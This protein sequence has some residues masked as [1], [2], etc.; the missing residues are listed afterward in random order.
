MTKTKIV[1][2]GGSGRSG[3]TF[4][5]LL[6]SQNPDCFDIGQIRDLPDGIRTDATCSCGKK[7]RVCE[8]WGAVAARMVE[9]FGIHAL[10]DFKVGL[11]D[12]SK[13][14]DQIQDW[15]NR[16]ELS[17]LAFR[18]ARFIEVAAGLYGICRMISGCNALIDSSKTPSLSLALALSSLN[19]VYVL[20]LVRDPRAVCASWSKL[21]KDPEKL[22]GHQRAWNR[23]AVRM[24]QMENFLGKA[25]KRI[26]YEDFA[27]APLPLVAEIQGW[28]GLNVQGDFFTSANEAIISWR[29]THLFPPAN[30]EVLNNKSGLIVI[31]PSESWKL[32]ENRPFVQIAQRINFPLALEV[33]YASKV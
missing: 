26:K 5:S 27:T 11:N 25:F 7:L 16:S 30:E 3:T 12:F 4:V 24:R 8:F 18:H 9:A 10:N 29:R 6:L 19:D 17:G 14:A 23:R 32:P 33:G 28:A 21:T 1:Y 13:S 20:N 31:R 2:L 22:E 15:S